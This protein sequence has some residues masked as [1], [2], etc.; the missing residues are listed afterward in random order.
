MTTTEQRV[1]DL[2]TPQGASRFGYIIAI[3]VNLAMLVIA[4]NILGVGCPFS[5]QISDRSCG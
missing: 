1:T 2:R 5:P 3:V 4:N